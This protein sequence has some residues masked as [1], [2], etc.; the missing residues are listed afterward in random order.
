M[1]DEPI[2]NK[3]ENRLVGVTQKI[4][5]E[6]TGL[7][8]ALFAHINFDRNRKPVS[9]SFSWHRREEGNTLNAVLEA[10]GDTVTAILRDG[11]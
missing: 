6:A 11:V 4:P 1:I 3:S 8:G 10:L 5:R 7:N 9:V 2:T